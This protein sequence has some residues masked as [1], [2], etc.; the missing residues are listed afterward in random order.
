[1]CDLTQPWVSAIRDGRYELAWALSEQ[2]LA[3]RDPGTRNDRSVPYHLR[4]IW[5]GRPFDGRDILVRCYH[6]LG[7]T[8]QFARYLPRLASRAA[9]LTVEVQP[10]L[11]GLLAE[12]P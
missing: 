8:I 4:W 3:A 2:A 5:D 12:L 1:M 7:D 11:C 9:S 6:G 10:R